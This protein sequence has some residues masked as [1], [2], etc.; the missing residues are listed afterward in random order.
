MLILPAFSIENVM[1]LI[2]KTRYHNEEVKR[3]QPFP[4]VRIPW[5][6]YVNNS[7]ALNG[8]FEFFS[9]SWAQCFKMKSGNKLECLTLASLSSLVNVC[10]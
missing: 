7:A 10:E 6:F 4:S 5:T 1:C 9:L 2:Y 3:T 8:V